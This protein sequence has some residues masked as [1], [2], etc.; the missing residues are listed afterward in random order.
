[1]VRCQNCTSENPLARQ[2]CWRCG[3]RLLV[4]SHPSPSDAPMGFMDEHVLERIS[5]VETAISSLNRRMDGLADTIERVAASN[6]IDHTM[7]ETLTDTIESAGVNL[8]NLE[9]AWRKRIDVR[10]N[11]SDAFERLGSR[12]DRIIEFYSGSERK[13]FTMWIERA[14]E[15]LLSDRLSEGVGSL[16][17]AFEQDPANYDLGMLLAEVSFEAENFLET[18]RCLTQ[19]LNTKPDHFEATLLM[20]FLEGSQGRFDA[21]QRLLHI[22]V[23]LREDSPSAHAAL[24]ALYLEQRNPQEAIRH[25]RRAL[26]LKPSAPTHF[27][28]GAVFYHDGHQR[29]AIDQLKQ[30][31]RLDPEFGEAFYQLGLVCLELKWMRK[32]QECFNR[33]QRLDPREDRYKRQVRGFSERTAT[34]GPLGGLVRDELHLNIGWTRKQKAAAE[35]AEGLGE[36]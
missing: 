17:S 6:F 8:T 26:E 24:G 10:L 22:A 21:A 32:A 12:I 27:M 7:I 16:R 20:G 35:V 1:M 19:V 11:E 2:F 4:A 13:Q 31:T 30:A 9:D 14:Y 36:R 15:H 34:T 28:L 5:A 29:R 3:S 23:E 33:A 25:L 18:G